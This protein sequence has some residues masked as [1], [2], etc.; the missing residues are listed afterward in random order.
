MQVG[1]I[2]IYSKE[3]SERADDIFN[4]WTFKNFVKKNGRWDYK[5]LNE[6]NERVTSGELESH[7]LGIAFYRKD[8]ETN[9]N[10]DL[11]DTYFSFDG[12]SGRSEDI[13]NHHFGVVGKASGLFSETTMLKAAGAAEMGKWTD[14]GKQVPA[15][16][17]PTIRITKTLYIEHGMKTTVT[18][19]ILLAPYGDNPVDHEWIKKG[20]KYYNRNRKI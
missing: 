5:N 10:A 15:S 8:K 4:P 9:P 6:S 16:W 17:R 12:T 11:S 13:N 18:E 19:E 1:G 20:F 7:I 14:E 3:N 2:R